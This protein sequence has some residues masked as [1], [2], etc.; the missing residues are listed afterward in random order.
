[1]SCC[2]E[3]MWVLVSQSCMM[4]APSVLLHSNMHK[5]GVTWSLSSRSLPLI[6]L[7]LQSTISLELEDAS[8]FSRVSGVLQ[9]GE[10]QL[11]L[12]QSRGLLETTKQQQQQ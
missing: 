5:K 7:S 1:M 9:C 11:R 10:L 2:L 12:V 8:C 4:L 3:G 6:L